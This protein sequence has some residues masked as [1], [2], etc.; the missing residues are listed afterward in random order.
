MVLE[1]SFSLDIGAIVPCMACVPPSVPSSISLVVDYASGSVTGRISGEGSG[2]VTIND[3]INDEPIDELCTSWGQMKYSGE[4][5]GSVDN[6]G[7][8]SFGQTSI[9]IDYAS[10]W[11]SGC[12]WASHDLETDAWTQAVTF[13]GSVKKEGSAN[14]KMDFGTEACAANVTWDAKA[15]KIYYDRD[16]D[17]YSD[18]NDCDDNDA[19]VNP[20]ASEICNGIDDDCDGLIDE[21]VSEVPYFADA[22][23]DGY[24]DPNDS[25]EAC[26][27]PSGYVDDNTDCDDADANVNPGA[28][29]VPNEIDDDC[30]GEIDNV[31]KAFYRDA[32]DDGYGDPNDSVEDSSAPP[33]YVEDNTDCDDTDAAVNPGVTEVPNGIDDDCD[34]EVD[35]KVLTY[36]RDADGDGYGAPKDSVEDSS[37]P[38]GYVED[39]TDCR[40]T[41]PTVH[42]GATEACNEV[43]DDCDGEVDEGCP[44]APISKKNEEAIP[45][46]GSKVIGPPSVSDLIRDLE[47]FLAGK[48]KKGPTPVQA[49][50]TGGGVIVL[51]SIWML[52]KYLSGGRKEDIEEAVRVWKLDRVTNTRDV[53]KTSGPA[54]VPVKSADGV[55]SPE[56]KMTPPE[57]LQRVPKQPVERSEGKL[58]KTAD[59][60][61]EP[62]VACDDAR[63]DDEATSAE[64]DEKSPTQTPEEKPRT[65]L[66]K[67]QM[68]D[69][70]AWGLKNN[71]RPEQIME[72]LN[73][74]DKDQGGSGEVKLDDPLRS[75]EKK[76]EEGKVVFRATVTES[77]YEMYQEAQKALEK[78]AD[79]SKE[80]RRSMK[81]LEI[82][83]QKWVDAEIQSPEG[84]WLAGTWELIKARNRHEARLDQIAAKYGRPKYGDYTEAIAWDQALKAWKQTPEGRGGMSDAQ[85]NERGESLRQ[86]IRE[87][88]ELTGKGPGAT[89]DPKRTSWLIK[90]KAHLD[91]ID[92]LRDFYIGSLKT[93]QVQKK[94]VLKE[95][96]FINQRAKLGD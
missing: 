84:R 95:I 26:G 81:G 52:E 71:R 46:A 43:D 36:H 14:G 29:E 88:Q 13:A 66:T 83:T 33:G 28:T 76:D 48:G 87:I 82:K 19:A 59:A 92:L 34:G 22:D 62:V 89:T 20:G 80:I 73:S 16:G 55:T 21:G 11:I 41:D 53:G 77:E 12:D 70:V 74:W 1:G 93:L 64:G 3:C 15:T 30:D 18:E 85:W 17:G 9:S 31:V 96:E 54:K 6:S 42:P 50:T 56:V 79:S 69:T 67:Q 78:I 38:S 8:V 10:Q 2:T 58:G 65:V 40:D 75:I 5:S 44:A 35:E 91:Q 94:E 60:T 32:D 37:A 86:Y 24:G 63:Q 90:P 72:D 51:V 47:E 7:V 23:G 4:L 27:A 45:P 39:D 25:V 68:Q 49:A 61:D 57:K